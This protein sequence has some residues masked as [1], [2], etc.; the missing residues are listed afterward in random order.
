MSGALQR[1][2][3][4]EASSKKMTSPMLEKVGIEVRQ[5]DRELAAQLEL[6]GVGG[7]CVVGMKPGGAA[8]KAGI[9]WGDNASL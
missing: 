9:T 3:P 1:R 2:K 8:E 7:L 6:K 4:R 5:I